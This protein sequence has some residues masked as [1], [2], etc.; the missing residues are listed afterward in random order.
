MRK[1][2]DV[3]MNP[4]LPRGFD[5]RQLTTLLTISIIGVE[6]SAA[7]LV[8]T[9]GQASA[10]K[11]PIGSVRRRP[12]ASSAE[13]LRHYSTSRMWN[14]LR[15]R[16]HFDR[17]SLLSSRASTKS[18]NAFMNSLKDAIHSASPILPCADVAASDARTRANIDLRVISAVTLLDCVSR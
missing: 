2:P 18:L 12:Q 6:D 1:V 16:S 13:E 5:W 14:V 7:L 4:F 10:V 3:Q 9:G 15:M 17:S 8:A 11:W